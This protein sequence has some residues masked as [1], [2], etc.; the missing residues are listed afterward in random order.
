MDDPRL[1]PRR[2]PAESRA[3]R[4]LSFKLQTFEIHA[5]VRVGIA[6]LGCGARVAGGGESGSL[7]A[8]APAVATLLTLAIVPGPSGCV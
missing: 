4:L 5:L 8:G 6:G 1:R 2:C 3:G 7:L